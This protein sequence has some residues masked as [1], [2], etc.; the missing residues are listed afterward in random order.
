MAKW[1]QPGLPDG[2]PSGAGTTFVGRLNHLEALEAVWGAVLDG[3]RQVVFIGGEPGV[4]KSR[5]AAE[6]ATALHGDGATVL[7]G[8]CHPDLDVPYRP[9]VTALDHLLAGG[10]EGQ[11]ADILGASSRELLRLTSEVSRHRP[12]LTVPDS[13]EQGSR[14]ALFRAVEDLL[15]SLGERRP[16]VVVLEDLH[17]AAGPT[18]ELVCHLAR[19]P[20]RAHLLLLV[21]HRTTAPDRSAELTFAIADLYR[22]EGVSRI[23]LEGLGTGEIV[24]YLVRSGGMSRARA[25]RSAALLRDQ[26]AGNPFFLHE[27]WRDLASRGGV[28]GW[29]S[30]GVQSPRSVQDTLDR[31]LAGLSE[32]HREALELI[33]VAGNDVEISLLVEAGEQPRELTLAAVDLGVGAGLLEADASTGRCRFVHAL[34]RQAVMDRTPPSRRVRMHARV[35]EVLE[36]RVRRDPSAIAELA[37]H[38][39][40]AQALGYA[41]KAVD[42]LV[43]AAEHA[44][45]SFAYEDAAEMYARAAEMPAT[46]GLSREELH[47]AAAH[48]HMLSGDFADARDVFDQL[49]RSPDPDLALRA[50]IGYE[51]SSWRPG[52]HG[53]RALR[54]LSAALRRRSSD[55]DD[56]VF[57]RALASMGRAHSFTGDDRRATQLGERALE[58]ARRVGDDGLLAHALGA[59]LWRGMTPELAPHLL[60]RALELAELEERIGEVGPSAFYRALFGY[61]LGRP[62]VWADARRD[63]AREARGG[64]EPFFRYVGGCGEYAHRFVRGE[65][66]EA[67]RIVAELEEL[68]SE[69]GADTSEGSHAV[70]TFMVRRAAGGLEPVRPL[71]TGHEDLEGIW[72][73][74]L[75]ALYREFEM[76]EAAAFVLT[77]LREELEVHRSI[78][79]Q[80]AGVL[81]F[82]VEAVVGLED[83]D[84]AAQLHPCLLE[85]AGLNLVAG[86]FVA[87]FG[88]ADR[89]LGALESLLGIPTADER[90]EAALDMDRRMGAVVHQVET[91]SAW[92]DHA[93]RQGGVKAATRASQLRAEA[94]ALAGPLGYRRLRTRLPGA[95]GRSRAQ[96]QDPA[97]LTER[98]RE[99]LRAVARGLSNREIGEQLFISQNT[100][101]NHVRSILMKLDA[102]NRTTAAMYAA[103][104]GIVEP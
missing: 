32:A 12:E 53:E 65:F 104:H 38:F 81:A 86:Q 70:Q 82:M 3:H 76:W 73:P 49:A 43:Q 41:D 37:H 94:Q 10:V 64:G 98:E 51:D 45:R 52:L 24:E 20:T 92:G 62:E 95:G 93:A 63:Q 1:T 99:V 66:A 67:A 14:T 54:L 28:E 19:S 26:T 96:P 46:R 100:A 17:W 103:E 87:V 21:T 16:V 22:H 18:V 39:S 9:F 23:D 79:S 56:P 71:I 50:A 40:R 91:L 15:V 25:L 61:M 85:Y 36:R 44:E 4:G 57:I 68:G 74:G 7:W 77:Q 29:H 90:F 11:F 6:A 69:F 80:W 101:A 75:L 13:D 27:V 34:V 59:T 31:R 84:A 83:A 33:A 30:A 55:P 88:S 60:E 72:L 2:F 42:Y 102:P 47:F 97:G 58:L 8:A 5:L 78:S 48:S 89:H 35:A